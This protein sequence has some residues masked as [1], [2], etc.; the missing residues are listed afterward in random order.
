MVQ[1]NYFYCKEPNHYYEYSYNGERLIL[2]NLHISLFYSH[3]L[4]NTLVY[5]CLTLPYFTESIIFESDLNLIEK[6][7]PSI[8]SYKD[9]ITYFNKLL[10]FS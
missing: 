7:D 3:N 2:P 10:I 8:E 4:E 6:I 5:N 1:L 9:P